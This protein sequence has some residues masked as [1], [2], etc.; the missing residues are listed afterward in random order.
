MKVLLIALQRSSA[1]GICA[2]AVASELVKRGNKVVWICNKEEGE[3]KVES[4][5]KHIYVK[6]RLA[7]AALN[8]WQ[9]SEDL[10]RKAAVVLN[11]IKMAITFR[12]WPLVSKRYS[13][14]VKRAAL[15]AS[16]DV[17]VVIGVY[18]QIDA[19][20]AAHAA[21]KKYPGIRFVA[22]FLDSF[23]GGHCPRIFTPDGVRERAQRW[24]R[25]LLDNADEIVVMES[26]RCFHERYTASEPYYTRIQYLDLPLLNPEREDSRIESKRTEKKTI[27]YAGTLPAGIRSPDFFLNVMGSEMLKDLNAIFI[28]DESCSVLNE[29]AEMDERIQVLGKMEHE[30]VAKYLESADFLLSLGNKISNMTPSKI[31]EYMSYRK[32][33]VATYPIDEDSSL[34]YLKCYGDVLLLDE[35][36]SPIEA[37]RRLRSFLD[38]QHEAISREA[39]ESRFRNNT[40]SA[41]CEVI[42]KN[43]EQ[44]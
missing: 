43:G 7:D 1:N 21:K 39:L 9:R 31:F 10:R 32:P 22:Y 42:D 19:L 14:R 8:R 16:A 2:H 6:P 36:S 13:E 17:D 25:R 35:R 4:G 11:R 38:K 5:I 30:E 28:G 37:S 40:P 20:I 12:S 3:P 23:A 34:D 33:I 44:K 27:V 29:A 18:T 15:K 26:A 41:F 24:C